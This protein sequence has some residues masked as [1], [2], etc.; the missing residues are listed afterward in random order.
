VEATHKLRAM[1]AAQR[2]KSSSSSS[3]GNGSA[4]KKTA[5]DGSRPPEV[6]VALDDTETPTAGTYPAR[7]E[8]SDAP[9]AARVNASDTEGVKGT[10][11]EAVH[12]EPVS[13]DVPA[14]VPANRGSDDTAGA[15]A[16]QED[17]L[18]VEFEVDY[19]PSSPDSN[20]AAAAAA[21]APAEDDVQD[22]AVAAQ[23][24]KDSGKAIPPM[25]GLGIERACDLTEN[26]GVHRTVPSEARVTAAEGKEDEDEQA[27][28]QEGEGED[29]DVQDG[30]R[31]RDDGSEG[32]E[33]D[34][35]NH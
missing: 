28:A 6:V 24:S 25:A 33:E 11:G 21:A 8:P 31:E 32:G 34:Q 9:S 3:V 12:P 26:V 15:V 5:T 18:E 2:S 20:I 22:G 16:A 23:E 27:Q 4:A 14:E 35:V 29:M 17:T 19:S 30:Q 7:S 10:E 13:T 1:I